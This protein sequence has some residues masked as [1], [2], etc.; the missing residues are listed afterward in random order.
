VRMRHAHDRHHACK[1]N[2]GQCRCIHRLLQDTEDALSKALQ[3]HIRKTCAFVSSLSGKAPTELS[4]LRNLVNNVATAIP[5]TLEATL[6]PIIAALLGDNEAHAVLAV[7]ALTLLLSATAVRDT[8][9]LHNAV[10]DAF[11][12]AAHSDSAGLRKK[13]TDALPI[14]ADVSGRSK[15][16]AAC[17]S[18]SKTRMRDVNGPVRASAVHAFGAL[19]S[20]TPPG[21]LAPALELLVCRLKDTSEDVRVVVRFYRAAS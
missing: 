13:V 14:V 1:R 11:L 20:G 10:V 4:S 3:V 8:P 7:D 15:V 18:E 6:A 5:R 12:S 17:V 16:W 19:V 9:A 2:S 21:D